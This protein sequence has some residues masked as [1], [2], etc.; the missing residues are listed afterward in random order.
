[1]SEAPERRPEIP[2]EAVWIPELERWEAGGNGAGNG[3]PTKSGEVRQYRADGTLYMV[4][5]Y[6]NGVQEG[7]FT[8]YHPDGGVAR[9]GRYQAGDLHGP[10]EARAGAA[11]GAEAEPLRACCVPPNAHLMRSEYDRGQLVYERFFDAQERLLLSD[12]SLYPDRPPGLPERAVFEEG[13]GDADRWMATPAPGAPADAPWRFYDRAGVLC[14]EA[15]FDEGW[16]VWTRS[17]RPD[18]RLIEETGM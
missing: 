7:P 6:E 8:I 5:R 18:G 4:C 12:G 1:M 2:A 11:G 13:H 15:R 16:K 17:L 10:L 3:S 9:Q 14:E